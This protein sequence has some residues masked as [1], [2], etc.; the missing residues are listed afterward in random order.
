M[1]IVSCLGF[2]SKTALFHSWTC[3]YPRTRKT[4]DF[5]P[6]GRLAERNV[7]HLILTSKNE[8]G[9]RSTLLLWNFWGIQILHSLWIQQHQSSMQLKNCKH[10]FLMT[11]CSFHMKIGSNFYPNS[12]RFSEFFQL[13]KI[14]IFEMS[15]WHGWQHLFVC[16][17]VIELPIYICEQC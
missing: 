4:L 6:K 16:C 12:C 17:T 9:V 7:Q 15:I 13:K 5:C 11:P 14:Q 10:I 8:G 1:I 3:K 2:P